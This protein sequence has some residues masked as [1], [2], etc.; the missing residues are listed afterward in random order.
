MVAEPTSRAG[1]G[2]CDLEL[3]PLILLDWTK[4]SGTSLADKIH[5]SVQAVAGATKLPL[6]EPNSLV[7]CRFSPIS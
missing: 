1:S 4:I 7:T 6:K 5:L 3:G 2:Q